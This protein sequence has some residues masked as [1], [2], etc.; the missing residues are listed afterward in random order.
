[1]LIVPLDHFGDDLNIDLP[2]ALFQPRCLAASGEATA[3]TA[4]RCLIYASS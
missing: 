4:Q 1:M 2:K 3:S